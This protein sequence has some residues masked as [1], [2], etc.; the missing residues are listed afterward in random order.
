MRRIAKTACGL[1]AT[2]ICA[3]GAFGL[4]VSLPNGSIAEAESAPMLE[5][6]DIAI[7]DEEQAELDRIEREKYAHDITISCVALETEQSDWEYYPD[8]YDGSYGDTGAYTGSGRVDAAYYGDG[9]DGPYETSGPSHTMPGY[10][11]GR[12]ETYYSSQV[13]PHYRMGEWTVDEEGFYRDSQGRYVVGV[14]IDEGYSIGDEIE[15][16]KGTAVVMDY[17][18]TIGITDFYTDW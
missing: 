16:G 13:L 17:G 12:K 5:A 15:T 2:L 7:T 3:V 1:S 8:E 4:A 18:Y 9:T 11:N 6:H 10:Y 14:G